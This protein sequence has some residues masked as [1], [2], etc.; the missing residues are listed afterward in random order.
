MCSNAT[1]ILS[2]IV[3]LVIITGTIP[4]VIIGALSIIVILI[5]I[6]STALAIIISALSIGLVL[7]FGI[8][9]ST[10]NIYYTYKVRDSNIKVNV[11]T[12]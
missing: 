11:Y 1:N 2:I 3:I 9:T 12:I 7:Y 4:A 5:I 8:I 10:A 6:T